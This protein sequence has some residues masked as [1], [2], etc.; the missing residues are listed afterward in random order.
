MSSS[1]W[2]HPG[3]HLTCATMRRHATPDDEKCLSHGGFARAEATRCDAPRRDI[4]SFAA[5]LALV[6]GYQHGLPWMSGGRQD[7]ARREDCAL[8]WT[9]DRRPLA[10]FASRRCG[11]HSLHRL[12]FSPHLALW[13]DRQSRRSNAGGHG[14]TN[15]VPE[16]G[17]V[18]TSPSPSVPVCS[19]ASRLFSAPLVPLGPPR[20]PRSARWGHRMRPDVQ[21]ALT[22]VFV[23][24]AKPAGAG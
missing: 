19:T 24:S 15:V 16:I 8:G 5:T 20:V 4:M 17:V 11:D 23:R 21:R 2:L 12:S 14:G 13:R 22:D 7:A 6:A 10:G 1:P 9:G 18:Y 3:Y